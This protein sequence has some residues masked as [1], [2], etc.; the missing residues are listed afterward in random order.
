MLPLNIFGVGGRI[1]GGVR[2]ALWQ[3]LWASRDGWPVTGALGGSLCLPVWLGGLPH[4]PAPL[5]RSGERPA[6]SA[7]CGPGRGEAGADGERE[8]SLPPCRHTLLAFEGV[9]SSG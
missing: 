2:V 9:P 3:G 1:G 4:S 7:P 6:P 5:P 8:R